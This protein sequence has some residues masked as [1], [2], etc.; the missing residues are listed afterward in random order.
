[1]QALRDVVIFKKSEV[2]I[3]DRRGDRNPY[4]KYVNETGSR[5]KCAKNE[6]LKT[7]STLN[8]ISLPRLMQA[9]IMVVLIAVV[10]GTG[11]ATASVPGIQR[12]FSFSPTNS[13][14]FK[15]A[16]VSCPS[17]K[18]VMSAGAH[19]NGEVGKIVLTAIDP[20]NDLTGVTAQA[21]ETNGGTPSNWNV[22]AYAVC[23][24]DTS[25]LGLEHR[26]ESSTQSS[27]LTRSVTAFCS[28]GKKLVGVGGSVNRTDGTVALNK[29]FPSAGMTSVN[30]GASEMGNGT[31][32][33]WFVSAEAICANASAVNDLQRIQ[34]TKRISS[35]S[36]RRVGVTALCPSG[37]REVGGAGLAEGPANVVALHSMLPTRDALTHFNATGSEIGNG[38]TDLWSITSYAFC[39]T[40]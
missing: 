23:A 40:P 17:G 1:M 7:N 12:V 10:G 38:T 33:S 26:S 20:T 27:T 11:P 16:F 18:K 37:K 15:T 3:G 21:A 8:P 31:G 25:A 22:A 35:S 29:F 34:L 24:N 9:A 28:N 36:S 4:T 32:S 14:P 13:Q 2:I 19:I 6:W 39:V 5:N 30:V